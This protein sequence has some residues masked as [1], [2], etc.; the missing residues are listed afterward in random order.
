MR[1]TRPRTRGSPCST[2]V[3]R[4]EAK[5]PPLRTP[6]PSESQAKKQQR[7]TRTSQVMSRTARRGHGGDL[8]TRKVQ[9]CV[10]GLRIVASTIHG[11][12][13]CPRFHPAVPIALAEQR[14]QCRHPKLVEQA[15]RGHETGARTRMDHGRSVKKRP[16]ATR[17]SSATPGQEQTKLTTG[18]VSNQNGYRIG[19]I[20]SP[21]QWSPD[22]CDDDY[23]YRRGHGRSKGTT[24]D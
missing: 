20:L 14:Q 8:V 12:S 6:P 18:L 10:R 9:H 15:D 19:F 22:P 24:A 13:V 21:S 11:L 17:E 23:K 3:C 1:S 4:Q 2:C 5:A 7:R 16:A